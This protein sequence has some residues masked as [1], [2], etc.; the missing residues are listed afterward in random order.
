MN[1]T[2]DMGSRVLSRIVVVRTKF[3]FVFFSQEFAKEDMRTAFQ[4][5]ADFES[6]RRQ[7]ELEDELFRRTTEMREE[8]DLNN[9]MVCR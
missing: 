3:Y 7:K 6:H 4:L 2:F 8:T 1:M 9:N 5:R